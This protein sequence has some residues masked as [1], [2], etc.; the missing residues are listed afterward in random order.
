[1]SLAREMNF[2]LTFFE[3]KKK[4]AE[5]FHFFS[6][7]SW[8]QSGLFKSQPPHNSLQPI[9][10]F[11]LLVVSMTKEPLPRSRSDEKWKGMKIIFTVAVFVTSGSTKELCN[12][13]LSDTA[14]IMMQKQKGSTGEGWSINIL[15]WSKVIHSRKCWDCKD[16]ALHT[17]KKK[18]S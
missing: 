6:F 8:C 10:Y 14:T 3:W 2:F 18:S 7:D 11:S 15:P 13:K 12:T 4:L 5:K 1:L 16:M 9:G 17:A